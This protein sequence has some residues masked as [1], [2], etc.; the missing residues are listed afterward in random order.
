M[1]FKN[2]KLVVFSLA[3]TFGAFLSTTGLSCSAQAAAEQAASQTVFQDDADLLRL[4]NAQI[5]Q[6]ESQEQSAEAQAALDS[7][8]NQ[9]YRL[10]AE[11][12]VQELE[13]IKTS[14]NEDQIKVLQ[15]WLKADAA[16]RAR[17]AQTIS[18]L[19]A[20]IA[21]LEQ[22]QQTTSSQ[23]SSDVGAIR[24]AG[25]DARSNDKFRQMMAINYFNEMQ[26]EMGPASWYPPAGN[27]AYYSMGG[28]GFNGGQQLFGGY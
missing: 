1:L 25:E 21:R 24:E 13:K 15:N 10:Y 9:A 6:L 4:Q 14:A 26:T 12:R 20:R 3:L 22:T 28:M 7:Q 23:L 27:G 8:R 11:K 2:S 18:N 19:R 17:D 5:Q 16:L